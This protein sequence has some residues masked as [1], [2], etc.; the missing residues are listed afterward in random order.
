MKKIT[1]FIV[2]KRYWILT[3]FIIL[4]I[5]ATI[6]S[7]KVNI[8]Y[9]ISK[10]LPDT[11]ETRIGMDIMEE[12]FKE[13]ESSDKDTDILPMW[14]MALAIGCAI[15]ILIIMCESYIEPFLFLATI[16]MAVLLNNGTN[17]IFD[18]VSNITSSISAILQ[19][20]LSMDYSIMLIN[21]YRQERENEPNNKIQAMKNALYNTFTSILSSSVTTI[22]GLIALVFMSF[23]IGKDLGFVLAKGVLFSLICIFFVLPILILMCDKL[24]AKTKKKTP[25]IKLDKIGKISYKFRYIAVPLFI[26]IFISSYFQKGNLNI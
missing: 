9:E 3:L 1:D 19:M 25:H 13:I 17:I 24:I 11:S 16:L 20:A 10:Y 26:V 22:V 7:N 12:E 21:R 23:T 15:I 4:T 5:L 14:I 6:V 18:S 8:N 2:D